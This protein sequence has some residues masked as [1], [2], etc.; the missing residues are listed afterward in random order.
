MWSERRVPVT[1]LWILVHLWTD[2]TDS[3]LFSVFTV[4]RLHQ[5]IFY[6]LRC[7]ITKS[8]GD[9]G[10]DDMDI[11][12]IDWLIDRSMDWLI[13]GCRLRPTAAGRSMPGFFRRIRR[14]QSARLSA[15]CE[16]SANGT[17][18]RRGITSSFPRPLNPTKR[19]TSFCGSLVNVRRMLLGNC[20]FFSFLACATR[21]A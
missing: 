1:R 13:D 4:F 11:I 21:T 20:S 9:N 18:W 16:R 14:P 19:A 7:I 6:Y 2:F 17:R 3:T 15:T 8:E 10:I 5:G 12:T